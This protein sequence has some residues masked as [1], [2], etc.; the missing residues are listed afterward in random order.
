M[1]SHSPAPTTLL[2]LQ[3]VPTAALAADPFPVATRRAILLARLAAQSVRAGP[4]TRRRAG[5]RRGCRGMRPATVV[6]ADGHVLGIHFLKCCLQVKLSSVSTFEE[7]IKKK[8]RT[9]FL[10]KRHVF[11]KETYL[12]SKYSIQFDLREIFDI[13]KLSPPAEIFNLQSMN[14]AP[15]PTIPKIPRPPKIYFIHF[16]NYNYIFYYFQKKIILIK[17]LKKVLS[18]KVPH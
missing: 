4:R 2:V 17:N 6:I 16:I 3:H 14:P 1:L 18:E 8:K 9:I 13:Y 15:Q 12:I 5:S 10:L 11:S 7:N